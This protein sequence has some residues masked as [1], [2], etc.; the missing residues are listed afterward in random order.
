MTKD[1]PLWLSIAL[2]VLSAAAS[3][4]GLPIGGPEAQQLVELITQGLLGLSGI[5]AAVRAII[6]R[7]Q[8]AQEPK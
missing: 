4:Y 5:F 2:A 8:A 7:K 6:L 3:Y 1:R